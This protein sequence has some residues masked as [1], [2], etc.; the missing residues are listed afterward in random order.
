[1]YSLTIEIPSF[2]E[3]EKHPRVIVAR[4]DDKEEWT[5]Y[6]QQE[7]RATLR[8]LKKKAAAWGKADTVT[9]YTALYHARKAFYDKWFHVPVP[10]E[11]A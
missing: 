8:E 6:M 3:V 10:K 4:F 7:A 1:M 9:A 11:T 5:S 2:V